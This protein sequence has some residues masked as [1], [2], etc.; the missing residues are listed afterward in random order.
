MT[1]WA[2]RAAIDPMLSD[3]LRGAGMILD[4]SP[5][6][7]AEAVGC[8]IRDY[9]IDDTVTGTV[10][11]GDAGF[12]STFVYGSTTTTGGGGNTGSS[13][14]SGA[15]TLLDPGVENGGDGRQGAIIVIE[16]GA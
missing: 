15:G 3:A 6:E 8:A 13:S 10:N 4:L 2:K 9:E 1:D 14:A 16:F 11:V 5:P 12:D 7:A